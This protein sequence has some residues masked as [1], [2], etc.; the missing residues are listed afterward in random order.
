MV[1]DDF[2]LDLVK[3]F[4]ANSRKWEKRDSEDTLNFGNVGVKHSKC[5]KSSSMKLCYLNCLGYQ[6]E[7]VLSKRKKG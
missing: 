1:G 2:Y 4:Y 7:D 6:I 5:K 3:E